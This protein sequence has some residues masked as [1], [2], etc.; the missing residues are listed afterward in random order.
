[1]LFLQ[2]KLI[3]FVLALRKKIF[4]KGIQCKKWNLIEMEL[5]GPKKAIQSEF[6][7]DTALTYLFLIIYF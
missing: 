3:M 1:M 5:Y 6:R 4:Q 7:L 2:S